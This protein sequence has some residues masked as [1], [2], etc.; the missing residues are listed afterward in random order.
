MRISSA[1]ALLLLMTVSAFAGTIES[2]AP[3][4]VPVGSGEY[5]LE[6][7]GVRLGDL[8]LFSG[9][10]GR[11][12]LPV[13]SRTDTSVSTWVPE[14]VVNA[15]GTYSVIVSGTDG[16]SN[17]AKFGV[18]KP[19]G[20][21]LVLHMPP[22]VIFD[23][24]SGKGAIV[25]YSVTASGGEDPKPAISCEPASRTLFPIGT[26]EVK[27]TASNQFGE[28]ASD[29]MSVFVHDSTGPLVEVPKQR[30]VVPADSKEGSIVKFDSRAE[31]SIDGEAAAV[32]CSPFSGSL[33]P[34]GVTQVEC[35]AYDKSLNP[36]YG[37]FMVEV[38][39]KETSGRLAVHM[40]DEL[41]AEAAGRDGAKVNFTV[42]ASGGGDP[43]PV[44]K[45]DPRS[46]SL[47]P[48]GPTTVKCQASDQF[49]AEATGEFNVVVIDTT[50]PVLALADLSAEAND[51]GAEV[52]FELLGSDLT[53]GKLPVA[54]SHA[55]GSM[56]PIGK[57]VVEC[58]STDFHANTAIGTFTITVVDSVP[59]MIS[60]VATDVAFAPPPDL[61]LVDVDLSVDAVDANDT[62]PRCRATAIT[63]NEAIDAPGRGSANFD[64]LIT[65]PLTLKLRAEWNG[66]APRVYTVQIACADQFGN[67]SESAATVAV[68]KRNATDPIPPPRRRSAGH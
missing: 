45:C 36:G 20:V 1:V 52:K 48:L 40:P 14:E 39:D 53:D 12:E 15:A 29:Q 66:D 24:T 10:G 32:E 13:Q 8:V 4:S 61:E 49:G 2:L 51:G 62:M 27:C 65:G 56:F 19:K 30:I 37:R 11:F 54:C 68:P 5:F 6:I 42:T 59:P 18:T 64:W 43:A 23:A 63:A 3:S 31:D 35:V 46:G 34:V 21:P 17:S 47:F 25:E 67:Q 44:V 9:P 16:N 57:T 41:R 50:P 60:S 58:S 26:T 28:R 38:Q 22:P 55:S 7:R 33:F